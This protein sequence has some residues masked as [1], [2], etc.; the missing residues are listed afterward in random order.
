MCGLLTG[1]P[2]DIRDEGDHCRLEDDRAYGFSEGEYYVVSEDITWAGS[3][4][5]G[6]IYSYIFKEEEGHYIVSEDITWAGA[7]PKGDTY[8]YIFE[9]E[10]GYYIVSE[11][12]TWAGAGP[13]GDTYGYIFEED[14]RYVVSEDVTWAGSSPNGEE[15]G[16]YK[17]EIPVVFGIMLMPFFQNKHLNN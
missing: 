9:E 17:K 5:N 16:I 4:P 2:Y 13:K 1:N 6:D 10:E 7:G 15:F 12:I 8:G 11:D 3:S 14:D